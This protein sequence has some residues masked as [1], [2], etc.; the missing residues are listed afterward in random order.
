MAI[1]FD[2]DG[3]IVGSRRSKSEVMNECAS[4]LGLPEIGREEYRKTFNEVIK[5]EKVDTR[6]PVFEKLI[7][8]RE[9]A[10]QMSNCYARRSLRESIIYP[11]AEEV[12]RK[13][14][15]K[16]GLLTNGP[17]KVQWDKIK[18][19]DLDKYFDSIIVSGEIGKS[20][21]GKEIFEHALRDLESV[22]ENSIYVGDF[23][24]H[25]V[26]GARNAG[27]TSVLIKRFGQQDGP[28][29]DYEIN[30]L[31][32]LYGILDEMGVR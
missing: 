23:P 22:A 17:R 30:D 15:V 31:R 16:K 7:G 29:P 1:L 12:L 28:T 9:T 11:D 24:D 18:K 32:E 10:E 13:L 4:E 19:F 6:V 14:D 26:A 21:P 2:L 20:K 3:T 5:N 27:L 8:R 25:D